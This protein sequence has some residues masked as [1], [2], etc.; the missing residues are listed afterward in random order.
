MRC[1][2]MR[3]DAITR[4]QLRNIDGHELV[5]TGVFCA[6]GV[7]LQANQWDGIPST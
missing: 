1:D 2:V 3:C 7:S 6:H 5:Y 4:R